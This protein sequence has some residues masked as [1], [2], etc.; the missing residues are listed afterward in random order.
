MTVRATAS[1]QALLESIRFELGEGAQASSL[2]L[3]AYCRRS[4][5][6]TRRTTAVQCGAKSRV[7]ETETSG[8][9]NREDRHCEYVSA[10]SYR[11]HHNEP[12]MHAI[13]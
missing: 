4:Y 3:A 5:D 2:K 12:A 13:L 7:L 10:A 6:V 11:G 8:P 1:I 9:H